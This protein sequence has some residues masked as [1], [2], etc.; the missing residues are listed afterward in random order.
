MGS[1]GFKKFIP[2]KNTLEI[3][4]N[5]TLSEFSPIYINNYATQ[6][7]KKRTLR[8]YESRLKRL[9]P[10]I[11][12]IKLKDFNPLML[13]QF[14]QSL[15]EKGTKINEP[16]Q[17]LSPKS[18]RNYSAMLSSIF[19]MALK[20]GYIKESPMKGV[21]LPKVNK[22][23]VTSLS[24]D[25]VNK[26]I[27]LLEEQA[28]TKY[29][30]FIE[31]ILITG[32]RRG[33]AV[34]L[35]WDKIDFNNG[36]IYI[37]STVQYDSIDGIYVDTTKNTSSNRYIKISKWMLDK[38]KE[39]KIEQSK[40]SESIH[41]N[42]IFTQNNGKPMHPNTPYT[43]FTRFQ[44]R[45]GL[46]HISIHS[47]RHTTATLLILNQINT[48]LVSGRL[49]HS[50]TKTTEDIYASYIKEADALVSDTLDKIIIPDKAIA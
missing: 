39:Y 27:L 48:K 14:F 20:W 33:E 31:L 29:K 16:E 6:A 46:Q 21:V 38:L 49:G 32:M 36:L 26:L 23:C 18:I 43:W 10:A 50:S 9:L 7:L 22:P 44:Q 47:L 17:G 34:G 2:T 3:N 15:Q 19:K 42:F 11:G 13:T 41:S 45:N 28:P 12:Y 1:T 24:T 30:I 8:D 37:N 40:Q 25:E 35:T 5:I 4:S